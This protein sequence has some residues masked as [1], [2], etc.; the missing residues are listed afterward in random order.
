MEV[1]CSAYYNGNY[2]DLEFFFSVGS[3]YGLFEWFVYVVYVNDGV[4]SAAVRGVFTL[5][6]LYASPSFVIGVFHK[7]SMSVSCVSNGSN[8]VWS[9]VLRSFLFR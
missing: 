8:D 4:H 6:K 3:Q 2:L 1:A 5:Y 7:L 9:V